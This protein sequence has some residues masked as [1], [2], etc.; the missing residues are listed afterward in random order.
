MTPERFA[1]LTGKFTWDFSCYYFIETSEGNFSY[2]SPLYNGTG[3][4]KPFKGTS[5]DFFGHLF[6]RSKG[7]HIVGEF[8]APGWYLN[9]ES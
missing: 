4:V 5:K 6:G 9:M 3:E 2:S 1:K 7:I 8:L